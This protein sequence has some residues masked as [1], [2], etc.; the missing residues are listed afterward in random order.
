MSDAE[1]KF[2]NLNEFLKESQ[3][4]NLDIEALKKLVETMESQKDYQAVL[5][6]FTE[7]LKKNRAFRDEMTKWLTISERGR[8]QQKNTAESGQ[9]TYLGNI[10]ELKTFVNNLLSSQPTKENQLPSQPIK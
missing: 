9:E 7:W 10:T 8:S 2:N 3:S 4:K 1:D 5:D 6:Q